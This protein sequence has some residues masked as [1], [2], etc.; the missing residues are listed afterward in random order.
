[1]DNRGWDLRS[2]GAEGGQRLRPEFVRGTALFISESANT[3]NKAANF[4]SFQLQDRLRPLYDPAKDSSEQIPL[5]ITSDARAAFKP[6]S[7]CR[8]H[9]IQVPINNNIGL[10]IQ[11]CILQSFLLAILARIVVFDGCLKLTQ[12]N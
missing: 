7:R 12:A 4:C 2:S 6:S 10:T 9:S 5:D 11:H 1:V 3:Q 8:T